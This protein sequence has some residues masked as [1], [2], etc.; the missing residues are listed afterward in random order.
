MLLADWMSKSQHPQHMIAK[1]ETSETDVRE[2]EGRE[3]DTHTHKREGERETQRARWRLKSENKQQRLGRNSYTFCTGMGADFP[4]LLHKQNSWN[5][6]PI[7]LRVAQQ[8]WDFTTVQIPHPLRPSP[9]FF[10]FLF[11]FISGFSFLFLFYLST[12]L[13]LKLS[14]NN[15]S[16]SKSNFLDMSIHHM[17]CTCYSHSSKFNPTITHPPTPPSHPSPLLTL[18]LGYI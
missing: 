7:P 11:F 1:T 2:S 9:A 4:T 13:A 18:E 16:K 15:L 3:R 17:P 8:I 14:R 6:C 12:S 10:F 5:F